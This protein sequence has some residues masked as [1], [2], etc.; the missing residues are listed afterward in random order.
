MV[1][2]TFTFETKA[3]EIER[4]VRGDIEFDDEFLGV[5]LQLKDNGD[6]LRIIPVVEQP[7]A[8]LEND[9]VSWVT[10]EDD[11]PFVAYRT[12]NL[13]SGDIVE[14]REKSGKITVMKVGSPQYRAALREMGFDIPV[15]RATPDQAA[16]WEARG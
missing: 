5:W 13:A 9:N 11:R 15:R 1:R 6:E 2:I 7:P 16:K 3:G 8:S 4:E 10:L 12:T 14:V